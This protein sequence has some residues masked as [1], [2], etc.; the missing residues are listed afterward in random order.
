MD[1][2]LTADEPI[3]E[4]LRSLASTGPGPGG[5]AAAALMAGM[6]A[7]LA[8]MVVAHRTRRNSP[9]EEV[10]RR[11]LEAFS[12]AIR[13]AAPAMA[14]QDADA[15]AGFAA[16]N[17]PDD[18]HDRSTARRDASLVAAESAASLGRFASKL[19]PVLQELGDDSSTL[20]LADVGVAAATL[21]AST[22]AAALNVC[23]DLLLAAEA[24]TGRSDLLDAFD[25]LEATTADL[26]AIVDRVRARLHP[27]RV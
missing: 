25:E 6:A 3:S 17:Q 12:A 2:R 18:P 22:R 9:D 26:L 19:V 4:W 20:L 8:E 11:S 27:S 7:A 1:G 13:D 10:H 21:A 14:D 16:A 15:S 24:G 5:G 23:T